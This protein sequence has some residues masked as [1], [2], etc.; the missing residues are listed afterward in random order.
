VTPTDIILLSHNRL[1]YLAATVDAL[2]ERTP[3]PFRLTIVDNASRPDVRNWLAAN[4]DRIHRVIAL[5][6]NEHVPAFQYGIDATTSDPYVVSDP[7]IEV[8]A[9]QPS[10]LARLH[11]LLERHPDYGLVGVAFAGQELPDAEI[12]DANVGTWFQMIRRDALREPYVKDSRTCTAVR[13]AGYRV[14]WTPTVVARNL[15]H[16]DPERYPGHIA[17]KNEVVSRRVEGGEFSPY[18]FYHRE[19]ERIA[20]P[21]ALAELARAAPAVAEIRAVEI[22]FPSVLELAWSA[23]AVAAAF[24]EARALAPPPA[25][26]PLGD[27]AAGAVVLVEPPDTTPVGEAFRVAAKLV[28]LEAGLEAVGGRLADELA[29]AGWEATERS[30]QGAIPLELARHGDQIPELAAGERFTTL[31]HRDEWLAFFAA[32]AFGTGATRLFVF[33][34]TEPLAVPERVEA[35]EDVEWWQPEPRVSVSPRPSLRRRARAFV[36]RVRRLRR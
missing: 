32:G 24:P 21:P 1:D 20:R 4:R 28:V 19:L 35:P 9:L 7:D 14:G 30:G 23:P 10:W 13:E 26:L 3:E 11:G 18:V 15:G 16:G 12:V 8:P 2:F 36:G 6:E 22:P 25:R 29:P 17:A 31:E 34:R 33:R 27:G 5:P